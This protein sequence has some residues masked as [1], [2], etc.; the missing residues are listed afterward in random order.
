MEG[1]VVTNILLPGALAIIMFGLGLSL[2]AADFRRVIHMPK[3]VLVGLFAQT[4][5][6]TFL[7]AVVCRVFN[8]PPDLAIGMML[9]A[10]APGGASANIFSHLAHGDLALNITLTAIN[11]VLALVSLPL[12]VWLSFAY[13]KAGGETVPPPFGKIFEV[14][15]VV[16]LPVTLG[17]LVRHHALRIAIK[18]EKWVRGI[19]VLVLAVFS[20]I[21]IWK[22]SQVLVEHAPTIGMAC[23]TFNLLSMSLGYCLPRIVGL[24]SAQAIAVSMEVGIHNA[25]L[26][27]FIAINILEDGTYA[28]PAAIYSFVMFVTA[29]IVTVWLNRRH[30]VA[31]PKQ[32][33]K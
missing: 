25:A 27:M 18:A 21:A 33:T 30:L 4:I 23:V 20:A 8:L 13:F 6:L 24:S 1:S 26:A 28:I 22:N 12:I 29:S 2:T 14:T 9:L 3:A 19:S 7:C 31:S 15:L 10:A 5:A 17:M 32:S 16:L 11:S